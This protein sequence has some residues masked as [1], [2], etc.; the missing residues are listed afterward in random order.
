MNQ[1]LPL[2]LARLPIAAAQVVDMS[3]AEMSFL[4]GKVSP[5][6]ILG[7]F[8]NGNMHFSSYQRMVGILPPR[9]RLYFFR[10]LMEVLEVENDFERLCL[11]E[12]GATP[13]AASLRSG[14]PGSVY[15]GHLRYWLYVHFRVSQHEEQRLDLSGLRSKG[16]IGVDGYLWNV[17]DE[18]KRLGHSP[19][20]SARRHGLSEFSSSPAWGSAV[21]R[22][23]RQSLNLS[24]KYSLPML[25]AT[26]QALIDSGLS[27][28]SWM[29]MA[30]EGHYRDLIGPSM[31]KA[32]PSLFNDGKGHF[33]TWCALILSLPMEAK[34]S[35]LFHLLLN[36]DL[37]AEWGEPLRKKDC[38]CCVA[39]Q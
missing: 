1:A 6:R 37:A 30:S 18:F 38:T 13:V 16:I 11:K 3:M 27:Y 22:F 19:D 35:F 26:H 9:G 24:A 2:K 10:H 28:R 21:R 17:P 39:R 36:Y 14:V 20:A 23:P 12:I 4:M 29:E 31:W 7:D 8:A 15:T 33:T 25:N 34:L 5:S 32:L